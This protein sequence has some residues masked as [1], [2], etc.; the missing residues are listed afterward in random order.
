VNVADQIDLPVGDT[1]VVHA[2]SD[3][4]PAPLQDSYYIISP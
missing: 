3:G 2:V 4:N 1:V